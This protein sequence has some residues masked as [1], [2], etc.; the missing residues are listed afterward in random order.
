MST[1]KRDLN[2]IKKELLDRR[3]ELE[4]KLAQMSKE[5]V[6]DDQVQDPGDQALSS[7]MELLKSSFEDAEIE[8]IK[9]IERALQKIED[10]SYGIC[11]DCGEEISEKRLKSN[12]NAARCL[13]CQEAFEEQQ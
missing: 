3:K 5:K 8:E 7:T 1:L 13:S 11:V 10:G 6:S 4:E 12:P 9:R 2:T